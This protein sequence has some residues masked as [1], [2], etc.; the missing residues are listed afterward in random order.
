VSDQLA[1]DFATH[2]DDMPESDR[3]ALIADF[4]A[5][6]SD[7][8]RTNGALRPRPCR[9]DPSSLPWLDLAD[10]ERR[11]IRCGRAP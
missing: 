6:Y 3:A 5:P 11:C 1:F 8:E 4:L 10:H 9:C 2:A 7:S